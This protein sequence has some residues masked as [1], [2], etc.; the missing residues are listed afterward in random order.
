MAK[1]CVGAH[2]SIAREDG[3]GKSTKSFLIGDSYT[4]FGGIDSVSYSDGAK[5]AWA[6]DVYQRPTCFADVMATRAGHSCPASPTVTAFT[7]PASTMLIYRQ[8]YADTDPHQRGL[9]ARTCRGVPDGDGGHVTNCLE[10]EY[11]T[12]V[13][14][15]GMC[16]DGQIKTDGS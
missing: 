15:G 5:L 8:Y 1:R 6:Y 10:F 9:L 13:T 16:K 4:R 12:P 2:M 7:A 11:Y 14:A 3:K